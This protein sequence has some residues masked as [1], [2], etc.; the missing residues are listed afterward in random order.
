[1]RL[2]HAAVDLDVS[3]FHPGILM[4]GGVL[5]IF[6]F[7]SDERRTAELYDPN[8]ETFHLIGPMLVPRAAHASVSLSGAPLRGE[9][10]VIGDYVRNNTRTAELFIAVP[11]VNRAVPPV[12]E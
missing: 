11:A 5:N 9:G 8:T 1:P 7:F 12:T 6:S 10:L 2:F 4:T 3:P